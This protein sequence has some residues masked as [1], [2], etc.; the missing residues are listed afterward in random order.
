[1]AKKKQKPAAEPKKTPPKEP[2]SLPVLDLIDSKL[3]K[4]NER[5]KPLRLN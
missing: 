3:H 4:T 2:E 1:M 5:A